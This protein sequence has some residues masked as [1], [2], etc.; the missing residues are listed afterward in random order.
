MDA[1]LLLA[2]AALVFLA[3]GVQR[4]ARDRVLQGAGR[5]WLMVGAIFAAV[6]AWLWLA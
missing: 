2:L 6:S 4:I 5:T 3:A 1:R